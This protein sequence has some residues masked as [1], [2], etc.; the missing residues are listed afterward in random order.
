MRLLL[1]SGHAETLAYLTLH[2]QSFGHVVE[3]TCDLD[4]AMLFLESQSVDVAI[5]DCAPGWRLPKS[6]AG[7]KHR[8][9]ILAIADPVAGRKIVV[10]LIESGADD[11][12]AL[13]LDGDE[14]RAR[15]LSLQ[16]RATGA[17]TP[18]VTAGRLSFDPA[19]GIA[20]A[21]GKPMHLTGKE[22]L[23][24]ETLIMRAGMTFSKEQLLT[25]LYA[26]RDEADIKI[27]DVFVCRIRRKISKITG[28][29]SGIVTLWGRGYSIPKGEPES[30]ARAAA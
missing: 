18:I 26:G 19:S 13:P 29:N 21:D 11:A 16:R 14:F 6:V 20:M 23:L 4:E 25:A 12:L 2:L 27:V 17:L 22:R 9:S 7:L 3:G 30:E 10:E 15:L 1:H 24:F 28:G 5:V 8:P